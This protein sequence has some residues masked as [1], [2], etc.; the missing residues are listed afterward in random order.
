MAS[1]TTFT[2]L[3][4]AGLCASAFSDSSP[5]RI[6]DFPSTVQLETGF[7]RVWLQTCVGSVL[8][9]RHVLTAAHCLVGT[10]L[11]PRIS[12]V[13]AGTSERGRGGDVWEVNSILRHPD[14][15]FRSFEANVGIV[16]LQYALIFGAAIQQAAITAAGVNFPGNVP[17]TLAGWGRTGQENIWADRVLHSTQLYTVDNSAC[18][19]IYGEL[20]LPISVSENMICAA[21]LGTTGANFGVRDGGSPVFYDGILVG[22]VSF[23]S[24]LSKTEYPLVATAVSPYTNWIVDNAV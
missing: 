2:L 6:E 24:P 1:Y 8:T 12:R 20:K 4:L 15:S 18:A 16:R 9:S 17:V 13:R 3:V 7:G 19:N 11:T 23:G 10:A 21:Q 22:F 5:A 14:Y